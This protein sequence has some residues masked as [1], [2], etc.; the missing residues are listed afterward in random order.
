MPRGAPTPRLKPGG[1]REAPGPEHS[2]CPPL[3]AAP[4]SVGGSLGLSRGLGQ[5]PSCCD[6]WHLLLGVREGRGGQV[7]LS[8][9]PHPP[10]LSITSCRRSAGWASPGTQTRGCSRRQP[11]FPSIRSRECS[12]YMDPDI[13]TSYREQEK[14][15][16]KW[17]SSRPRMYSVRKGPQKPRRWHAWGGCRMGGACRPLTDSSGGKAD[18]SVAFRVS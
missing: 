2:P 16:S 4:P 5:N 9:G 8:R 12:S 18:S 15:K 7:L 10:M 1:F 14:Q 11:P 6:T 3:L 13:G 17:Q